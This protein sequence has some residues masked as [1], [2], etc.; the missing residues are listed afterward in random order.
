MEE[1]HDLPTCTGLIDGDTYDDTDGKSDVIY[2]PRDDKV[3]DNVFPTKS[4]SRRGII[5]FWT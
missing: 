1:V 4:K 3:R 2:L 5:P